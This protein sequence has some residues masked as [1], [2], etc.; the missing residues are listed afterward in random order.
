MEVL[1]KKQSLKQDEYKSKKVAKFIDWFYI[2]MDGHHIRN[3]D[4]ENCGTEALLLW[5]SKATCILV[6][7]PE[8]PSLS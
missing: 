5:P 6:W 8:P 2:K 3:T 4:W 7:Y 1:L